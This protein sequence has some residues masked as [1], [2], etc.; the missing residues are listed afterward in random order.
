MSINLLCTLVRD[1]IRQLFFIFLP[2]A[3][4]TP[5]GS[6]KGSYKRSISEDQPPRD[7]ITLSAV[8]N[9]VCS[10]GAKDKTKEVSLK[11]TSPEDE[12]FQHAPTSCCRAS[13]KE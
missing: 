10:C 12:I 1:L 11:S 13:E 7:T 6:P 9:Q 5:T 3:L 4:V 2:T 8:S